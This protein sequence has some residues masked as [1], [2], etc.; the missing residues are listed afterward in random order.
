MKWSAE[1][2]GVVVLYY[3]VED[4]DEELKAIDATGDFK[5]C[6]LGTVEMSTLSEVLKWIKESALVAK[7]AGGRWGRSGG[8]RAMASVR[9]KF[10][11]I[12]FKHI[13]TQ[14]KV[15]PFFD[16][17]GHKNRPPI[18]NTHVPFIATARATP[19]T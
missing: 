5:G 9:T 2:S 4:A 17:N 19:G 10:K 7:G 15:A 16:G 8:P 3:D 1:Y 13:S 14:K 11:H 12:H 6:G 18:T